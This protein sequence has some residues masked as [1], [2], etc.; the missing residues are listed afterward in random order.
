MM[1]SITIKMKNIARNFR[2]FI[3]YY[4]HILFFSHFDYFKY[5]LISKP[6]PLFCLSDES[7]IIGNYCYGNIKA[8]KNKLGDE[9]DKRC[10]IEHGVYFGKVILTKECEINKINTIYTFSPYRRICLQNYYQGKLKKKI[11]VI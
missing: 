4:S 7:G 8:V 1:K 10:M 5:K 6:Y 9:F 2:D 11:R 3:S